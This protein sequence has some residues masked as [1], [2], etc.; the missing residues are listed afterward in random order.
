MLVIT[1]TTPRIDVDSDNDG[2]YD[3]DPHVPGD[4]EDCRS[5]RS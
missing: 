3:P 5:G 2:G 4:A 1:D